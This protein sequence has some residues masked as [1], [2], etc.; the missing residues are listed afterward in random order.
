MQVFEYILGPMLII[1]LFRYMHNCV[2]VTLKHT[3]LA[4][5]LMIGVS[6]QGHAAELIM[7]EEAGCVYCARFN[8]EIA[9]VYP[10][11]AEGKLAPLRRIDLS[12]EWPADLAQVKPET[13]TPTFILVENQR[14]VGRLYGYQGDEFFWFLLGE[15]LEKLK[16]DSPQGRTQ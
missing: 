13:I 6:A 4:L 15:M 9:P 7:I 11:T 10:K 12:D 3:V 2:D 14:E 8:A 16:H 1:Y 5:L